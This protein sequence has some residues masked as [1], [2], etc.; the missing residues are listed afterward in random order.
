MRY[1]GST[2]TKHH[3]NANGDVVCY[4]KCKK[5][6]GN[7]CSCR[8]TVDFSGNVTEIGEHGDKCAADNNA[9]NSIIPHYTNDM[10]DMVDELAIQNLSWTA[11]QVW[12]EIKNILIDYKYLQKFE[13]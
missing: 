2:Y 1:K 11:R 4:Y 9:K 3:V 10:M 8:I 12:S 5:R 7:N 13:I 6:K